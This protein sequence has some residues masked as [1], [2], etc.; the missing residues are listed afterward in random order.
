MI[1][2]FLCVSCRDLVT[3]CGKPELAL[4]LNCDDTILM[5]R[6]MGRGASS[7]NTPQQVRREDDNF[8]SALVRLRTFHKYHY[9]TLEWIREQHVPIINL[10]CSGSAESVWQQLL[11]IGR[12]MRP[13]VKI[14]TTSKDT[15]TMVTTTTTQPLPIPHTMNATTDASFTSTFTLTTEQNDEAKVM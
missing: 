4:H 7:D 6:I 3:L 10:D 9:S 12:L 11:A 1:H 13:A 2:R 8:Q 5:E 15:T 14:P